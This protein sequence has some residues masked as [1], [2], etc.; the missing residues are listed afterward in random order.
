MSQKIGL[1]FH[2]AFALCRDTLRQVL[3]VAVEYGSVSDET[4]RRHSTLGT[5]QVESARNY[6]KGVGLL[7]L[8]EQVTSFGN[9][10]YNYDRGMSY[11]KTQWI[12]HYHIASPHRCGPAYWKHVIQKFTHANETL[13]RQ[14][15]ADEIGRFVLQEEN[16]RI[17]AGS[18]LKTATAV[19]GSYENDDALF[20]IRFWDGNAG[21]YSVSEP[22]PLDTSVFAYALAD[23]WF[24]NWDNRLSV[25][26]S[27]V[28]GADGPAA[29]FLLRSGET[30]QMLREMQGMGLVRL[31]SAIPPYAV[32][33]LWE[34]PDQLL[35][36]VYA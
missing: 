25:N 3:E 6:A 26:K 16:R 4:L 2:R 36:R 35:E 28:T 24:H 19:L 18:L 14:V 1:T 29:L 9:L 21:I 12:M 22:I 31:E 27:D 11:E 34:H 8:D 15:L 33:R 23:Y 7:S 13:T 5:I 17:E 30:N 32:F 10:V 20:G